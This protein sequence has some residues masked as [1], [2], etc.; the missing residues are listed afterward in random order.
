MIDVMTT[1]SRQGPSRAAGAMN[2]DNHTHHSRLISEEPI[3]AVGNPWTHD[4]YLAMDARF[5]GA[6][7]DALSA[8]RST[9]RICRRQRRGDAQRRPTNLRPEKPCDAHHPTGAACY[10]L[11]PRKRNRRPDRPNA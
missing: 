11:G 6:M 9:C 3:A 2:R 1:Q 4:V 8:A 5:R 10:G 7:L